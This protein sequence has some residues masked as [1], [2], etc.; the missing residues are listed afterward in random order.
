MSKIRKFYSSWGSSMPWIK[1][2]IIRRIP[3]KKLRKWIL[4][5]NGADIAK[6]VSMFASVEIRN[7]KG[8]II[9]EGVQL[10][11]KFF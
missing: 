8:L 2:A 5:C 10:G 7:P 6:H 4:K 3:S 11:Q 1:M 9:E